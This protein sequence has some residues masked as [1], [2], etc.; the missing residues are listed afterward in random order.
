MKSDTHPLNNIFIVLDNPSHPGNIG[1]VARAMLNMGLTEL[2]LVT[3]KQFPHAEATARAAGADSVLQNATVYP[4]LAAA[5][6][7]CEVIVGTSA[8][9]RFRQWPLLDPHQ[10]AQEVVSHAA[11]AKVAFIFGN[12]QSGLSNDQLALCQFHC[13]I[14]TNEDYSSLNLA[15]AVQICCYEIRRVAYAG[16]VKASQHKLATSA[17]TEQFYDHL[18]EALVR[19]DYLNR[20]N[21]GK[22]ML[23]LRRL[24]SRAQL[25]LDEVHI[26]RG[27]CSA[28]LE[29]KSS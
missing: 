8:R 26:L 9:K 24:F 29:D 23:R 4:D 19:L 14:G 22:L 13:H 21:P 27:I 18:T 5:V 6:A 20:S 12:E 3:P 28:I 15:Q 10:A 11:N 7:D 16:E 2:R 1:A 17:D 25:E